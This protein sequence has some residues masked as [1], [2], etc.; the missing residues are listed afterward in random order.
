MENDSVMFSLRLRIKRNECAKIMG[1][2]TAIGPFGQQA[3]FMINAINN[4]I[5]NKR[6]HK[7]I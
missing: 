4:V 2:I 1:L 3:Q 6:E 7:Y 5:V